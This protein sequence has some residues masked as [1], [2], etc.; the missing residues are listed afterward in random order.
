MS[1]IVRKSICPSAVPQTMR[2]PLGGDGDANNARTGMV[3]CEALAALQI[4]EAEC[5]VPGILKGSIL[6]LASSPIRL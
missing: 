4:P 2:S 6:C 3:N 5:I 1:L